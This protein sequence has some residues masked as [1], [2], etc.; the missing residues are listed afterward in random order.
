MLSYPSAIAAIKTHAVAA[1]AAVDPAITDIDIGPPMPVSHRCVRIFYVGETEPAKMPGGHTLNSRMIGERIGLVLWIAVSNLSIP[2]LV[3]AE[4]TL[5]DFKHELRTRI[6]GDSQ[7]GG[8]ATDLEMAPFEVDY[9]PVGNTNYR[10]L[11]TEFVTD[12]AEYTI[13]P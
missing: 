11:E 4:T 1:G 6:L 8:M 3:A 13:A 12:F 5:Y 9:G 7:L 10:T 2:Q